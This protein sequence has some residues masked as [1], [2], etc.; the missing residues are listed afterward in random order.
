MSHYLCNQYK[1]NSSLFS[2]RHTTNMY[3]IEL[4]RSFYIH[5]RTKSPN[6][7]WD[8][9]DDIDAKN[10]ERSNLCVSNSKNATKTETDKVSHMILEHF[11]NLL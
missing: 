2:L 9:F 1:S 8:N 6:N 5:F 7:T 4:N 10:I 11:E 3:V